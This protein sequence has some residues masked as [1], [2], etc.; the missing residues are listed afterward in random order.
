V[1]RTWSSGETPDTETLLRI[2]RYALDG[3]LAR[4]VPEDSIELKVPGSIYSQ[5]KRMRG[6]GKGES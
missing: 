1:D 5:G 2:T 6:E 4:D 3:E